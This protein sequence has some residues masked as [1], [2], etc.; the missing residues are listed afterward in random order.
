MLGPVSSGQDPAADSGRSS[1]Q[2]LAQFAFLEFT[3]ITGHQQ[4]VFSRF[5]CEW[6]SKRPDMR[7]SMPLDHPDVWKSTVV[8]CRLLEHEVQLCR[9]ITTI[10]T[11]TDMTS[12]LPVVAQGL[13]SWF[14]I[15]FTPTVAS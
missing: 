12:I 3:N 8:S 4:V 9:L 11:C 1:G 14:I 15:Y 5:I 10:I 6:C 2:S 13:G 7:M